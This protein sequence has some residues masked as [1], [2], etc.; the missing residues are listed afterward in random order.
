MFLGFISF[1]F[2]NSKNKIN[3]AIAGIFAGLSAVTHL[4]G[5]IFM[6]AGGI[7]LLVNRRIFDAI[8]FSIFASFSFG[9]YFLDIASIDLLEKWYT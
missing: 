1:Y 4:N 5:L 8:I 2:I 6:G 7:L 9:F 3:I